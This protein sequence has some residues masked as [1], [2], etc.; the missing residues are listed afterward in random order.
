MHHADRLSTLPAYY[1]PRDGP[2]A[3]Y[4]DY[5]AQLPATEH[6]EVF[7]QHPNADIASQIAET[8]TLFDTLLSLQPRVTGAAAAAGPSKEDKVLELSAD[9]LGRLPAAIDYEGTR[10]LLQDEPSPLNVMEWMG[11]EEEEEEEEEEELPTDL[12][13]GVVEAV[14]DVPAQLQELAPLQQQ[15]VEEAEGEEQPPVGQRP[16]APGEALLRHQLV[17]TLHVGSDALERW[18]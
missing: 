8:R 16:R 4:L 11:R 5:V 10:A 13:V 3:A 1:I 9:V 6:P 14:D 2:R 7:G 17:Q 18:R 12:E 15:A